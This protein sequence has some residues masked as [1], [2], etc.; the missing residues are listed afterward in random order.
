MPL[1][2]L[3]EVMEKIM[4]FGVENKNVSSSKSVTD[5]K[6]DEKDNSQGYEVKKGETVYGLTK[7]FNFSSEAE[8]R[9]F[10]KLSGTASLKAG[11][12]LLVPTAKVETTFSA[13]ARKYNISIAELQEM[14]PQIQDISKI[15]KG[16]PL[17]VPNKP[18]NKEE[19]EKNLNTSKDTSAAP[20]TQKAI[21]NQSNFAKQDNTFGQKTH[22]D[23]VPEARELALKLMDA[24]DDNIAAVGRKEF[25]TAFA[26]VN[27]ENV[28]QV[29]EAYNKQYPDESLINTICSEIGSRQSTRKNAV[30]K[31]YDTLS[32]KVGPKIATP[33]KRKKFQDILN[34]EFD[35]W[36]FVST[37]EM[38]RRINSMI[39]EYKNPSSSNVI[40][41]PNAGPVVTLGNGKK[42][43]AG[44]LQRQ[45]N[46]TA[47]TN[48]RPV[49][50]PL[51]TVDENGKIVANVQI[52][53]ATNHD[54]KAELSKKT[55]I[56][57]AGHGGYNPKNGI[58][59]PGTYAKDA[60]GKI[61]EEWYKNK[62]FTDKII[63]E[64]TS[65][66]AKV[67]FIS[68]SAASVMK[69]KEKYKNADLFVSI[70]CDSAVNN[71]DKRGQTIIFREG[72]ASS[73]RLANIVENSIE[74]HN[75]IDKDSCNAKEDVR[76]LG[77]LRAASSIPSV[78]I[79]TGYQSN[80]KDLANIDSDTFRTEFAKNL[81]AGIV[82]YFKQTDAQNLDVSKVHNIKDV[83]AKTGLSVDYLENLMEMEEV[84]YKPYYDVNGNLTI[85]VGHVVQKN[86][87]SKYPLDKSI[88]KED[89]YK[90]LTKDMFLRTQNVRDMIGD[91][92]YN[93]M[94]QPVKDAVMDFVFNRGEPIVKNREGFIEALKKGD[95][96]N[97]IA[98][99][100]VDYSIVKNKKGQK[101]RKH[102]SG[103]NKRR[104]FE[105]AH[106]CKIYDGDIPP[107]ILKSANS[108]YRRGLY[109]LK[110]EA[111]QDKQIKKAYHN[112]KAEY[113]NLTDDWFD[114]KIKLI[115]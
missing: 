92:A 18:Y 97:A 39:N 54:E 31:L 93:K 40:A 76:N 106:A 96:K 14:N 38:D 63:P 65:K 110:Q 25:D 95:Y 94:P 114:G 50:R 36:G 72:N 102:L 47:Q 61:I 13:I 111:N 70:H 29:I 83:S 3:C 68:G 77:V 45:A 41:D 42:L 112:I 43:K 35:S 34:D 100:D 8:F 22:Q 91:E 74:Q 82:K 79:E 71:N 104:L 69:A 103:L 48:N 101:V 75:W 64:L 56:I 26:K 67:I 9:K 51:P 30:M 98:K 73:K 11:Q 88:S 16:T 52:F 33:E 7:K 109:F 115:K 59:D 4:I 19:V 107:E 37:K 113:N 5:K 81:T 49:K 28:I 85:G 90:L 84:H 2:F 1:F 99:M 10:V 15:K 24:A 46:V 27:K 20:K 12:K 62:N 21:Y 105:M 44:E 55:I 80:S 87:K 60:N 32:Q 58:F 17:N 6:K 108:V 23:K 78:L 53:D 89:V 57:N 86:E 66:G